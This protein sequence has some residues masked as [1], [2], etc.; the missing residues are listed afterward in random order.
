M[1]GRNEQESGLLG[2]TS[3][4]RISP[5]PLEPSWI[6]LSVQF[7]PQISELLGTCN[8]YLGQIGLEVSSKARLK[9]RLG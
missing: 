9:S 6:Y 7:W 3:L 1:A 5:A 8:F 2:C 4:K